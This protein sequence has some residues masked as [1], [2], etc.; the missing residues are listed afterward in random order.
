MG[1]T[2]NYHAFI[3]MFLAVFKTVAKLLGIPYGLLQTNVPVFIPS[4]GSI[5][6]NGALTLTTAL[7]TT[8]ANCYLYFPANAIVAGSAAGLYY[9]Q[10]SSTTVGTIFNNTYSGGKQTIPSS[11]TAFATTG[12]GAYTQTTATDITLL[13]TTLP[14]GAMGAHGSLF[15][16]A[17]EVMASSGN[18][19]VVKLKIGGSTVNQQ[20]YT[21][22]LQSTAPRVFRNKGVADRNVSNANTGFNASGTTG[23]N[24]TTID[25]AVDQTVLITMQLANATDYAGLTGAFLQITPGV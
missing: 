20:G 11:P 17:Q 1:E 23:P 22:T 16:F 9:T 25:T 18:A 21:T 10:M 24:H 4:S 2:M 14:G 15:L 12:P 8:Y 7:D 5:G 6:N 19:K 13:S 3:Q